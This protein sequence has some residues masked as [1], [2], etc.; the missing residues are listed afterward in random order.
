MQRISIHELI[1]PHQ[2]EVYRYPVRTSQNDHIF[3][4]GTEMKKH[5]AQLIVV[6]IAL[7]LICTPLHAAT[8]TVNDDGGADFTSIQAA[9]NASAAGDVV[10]VFPGTYNEQI[11]MKD[12]VNLLGYGPH[13]T[14]I[15]GQGVADHVVTFSGTNGAVISGFRITGSV[16]S[17]P[18]DRGGIYCQS[19][20]LTIRNNIIENNHAGVSVLSSANPTI[21]NNTMVGNTNGVILSPRT[22]P[23]PPPHQIVVAYIHNADLASAESFAQLLE[24]NAI[25]V[26]LVPMDEIVKTDFSAY[27]AIIVGDDTGNLGQWG[28]QRM[29]GILAESGKPV[30][31]VGRGGSSFFQVLQLE[32]GWIYGWVNGAAQALTAVDPGH[33]VFKSP[34]PI[35]IPPG[36]KPLTLYGK[37][38]T[39][40]EIYLPQ[41][42]AN[43]DPLGRAVSDAQHYSLTLE[44]GKFLL[45]GFS[46]SPEAMTATGKDLF[47]NAL[48]LLLARRC[49]PGLPDPEI[50]PLGSEPSTVN[51]DMRI[52]NLAVTNW[53]SFPEAL[54][55]PSPYLPPCGLNTNSARSW[56]TVHA[57]DG[58]YLQSFCAFNRD[59]LA[60]S[61]WVAVPEEQDPPRV[62]VVIEDRLCDTRYVSN[63]IQLTRNRP[64]TH[65]IMNNIIVNNS[66]AGI[67]YYVFSPD[68][69]ILYNDVWGNPTSY[70]NNHTGSPFVPLPGTGEISADPLFVDTMD[71]FLGDGSPCRDTGHPGAQYI[72][73]D[74]TRN[75]MGAYGGPDASGRG[76]HPGSGFIFTSIGNIPTSEIVQD[77]L[78]PTLGLADVDA[79][80]AADLHIPA[81]DDAPFG[82]TLRI[83]GLFG[84]TDIADGVRYYQILLAPWDGP[85]DPP[86]AD[87]FEP[88][89]TG[90]AKV[91]YTPQ[92]DGTV[93]TQV[94]TLGPQTI[95]GI[96]NLYELTYQGWW[97]HIDLRMIWDTRTVPNGMY[98]LAYKAYRFH[99]LV[100][101]L[102]VEYFPAANEL[103]NIDILVNNSPV[104][105][106]INNVKYD[107]TSPNWSLA[108]DGEIPECGII[109]LQ[110]NTENL[111]FNITARHPDGYLRYWVLD[112]LWGKNNYAG[113]I[114]SQSYP[115]TI[116]PNNWP[117]V[118]NQEYNSADGS[119]VP[120]QPCAYQFRLRAYTR[121]TNGYDYLTSTVYNYS[122]SF[123][124]H[125]FIDIGTTCAW[126]GG[127]D[128]NRDGTVDLTDMAI[129]AQHYLMPC[130][131]SCP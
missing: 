30:L 103:D 32:T 79:A 76:T 17:G 66:S 8:R 22:T 49:F 73:P 88:L 98:R 55:E 93:L 115:G 123:S 81:Y 35:T 11:I 108:T 112:A 105:A 86:E 125:Y 19:G 7:M 106:V 84:E 126:C 31:G 75:D 122:D 101:G 29:V 5:I 114:A 59:N 62:Y 61:L 4:K 45:W 50:A 54:F 117:G 41:I 96:N 33:E 15:D 21:V 44:E 39:A 1:P 56:V 63:V 121:A 82:S 78:E 87:D 68:G 64:V 58:S 74:G 110:S 95:S 48:H 107:P 100:P 128:V 99:P 109:N 16:P 18:W 97:S 119:L 92:L 6:Q 67:F 72:D 38:T 111:R 36:G 37:P 85:S 71:Y 34:L 89:A 77:L 2:G 94:I 24:A 51:P 124:D 116:P 118:V 43:V 83:H 23:A 14:T 25:L 52:Y 27:D 47:I 40:I 131:V 46:G 113:V 12:E 13:V 120:W 53:A 3:L 70:L 69:D 91:K 42:P 57:E 28:D 26:A 20:P 80:T 10:Y 129:V 60:D 9:I 130:G 102:L 65:T 104:E 127:A 90:L